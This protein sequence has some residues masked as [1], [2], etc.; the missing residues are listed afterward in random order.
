MDV[1]KNLINIISTFDIIYL[2]IT[3]LSLIKC[4][5]KGFVLSI[6]SA[7]KWLLAYIITLFLFPKI[8]PYTSNI[9]DNDYVLNILL[10]LMI[11]I[12]VSSLLI[13]EETS[14]SSLIVFFESFI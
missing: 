8:R 9:I 6:L 11:F 14:D 10:G 12:F 5:K 13:W 7:S 3:G 2:V 1:L 4:Y